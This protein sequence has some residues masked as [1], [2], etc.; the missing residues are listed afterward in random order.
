M[1]AYQPKA[2]NMSTFPK[3]K[4]RLDW[5]LVSPELEFVEYQ[6]I[7]DTLSDHHGVLAL[8]RIADEKK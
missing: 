1:A 6:I 8:L 5:I 4:K 2:E 7:P 3:L